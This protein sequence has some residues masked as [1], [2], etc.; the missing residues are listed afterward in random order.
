MVYRAIGLMSGSSLDGLD[1]AFAE[2]QE[3]GG[4]WSYEILKTG[5][6]AYSDEWTAKLQQAIHLSARD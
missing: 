5:C 2:F 3:Q 4:K 1:I 6:Y